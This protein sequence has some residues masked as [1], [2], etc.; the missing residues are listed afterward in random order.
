MSVRIATAATAAAAA[1]VFGVGALLPGA[2]PPVISPWTVSP[3][4]SCCGRPG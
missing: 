4:G 1:A 3:S 2:Q